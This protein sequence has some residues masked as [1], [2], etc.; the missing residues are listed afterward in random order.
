M[1]FPAKELLNNWDIQ[2]SAYI[3]HR[4]TRFEAVLDV[5]SMTTCDNFHVVD[6]GCGPGT[7]SMR[8]LN[9]FPKARV[10]AIDLDPLLL[11]IAREALSE[12]KDR[13]DF[14]HADIAS[15]DCFA[16]INDAPQAVVSSTAIHWLMPEQQTVLYRHLF[17]LLAAG[18][19]FMNADHQ[20]FDARHPRQKALAEM[21]D[22]HTQQLAWKQGAQDWDTWFTDVLKYAPL[23]EMQAEREKIFAG[24]PLPLPTPVTCQLAMLQLAGFTETGTIWQFLDDYVI[25]GWK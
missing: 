3:A 4:E 25:A 8:L 9:R 11:T 2:Q 19:I 7:F 15:P 10:T 17:D 1:S 16:L 23:Q 22:I 20:R 18:G 5:L 13:I 24:R 21:H 14:I 12:H 6:I